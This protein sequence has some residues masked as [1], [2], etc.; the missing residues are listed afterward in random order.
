MKDLGNFIQP[1]NTLITIYLSGDKLTCER[2][3]S[4]I[5][6]RFSHHNA[7]LPKIEGKKHIRICDHAKR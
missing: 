5:D 4:Q 1:Q 2:A 6:A 3:K 7:G